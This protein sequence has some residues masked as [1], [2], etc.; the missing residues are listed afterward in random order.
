LLQGSLGTQQSKAK[1]EASRSQRMAEEQMQ[2]QLESEKR[3]RKQ[4]LRKLQTRHSNFDTQKSW[5]TL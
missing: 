5:D 1:G 4:E 2:Q 3:R